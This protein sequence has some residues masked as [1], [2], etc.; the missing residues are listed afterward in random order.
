MA[1]KSLPPVVNIAQ[2]LVED[3][4]LL[5]HEDYPFSYHFQEGDGRIMILAGDNATGKSLFSQMVSLAAFHT[6]EVEPMIVSMVRRT[7]SGLGRAMTYGDESCQS[8]GEMSASVSLKALRN[9]PSRLEEYGAGMVILDE[10]DIGLSEGFS[11]AFGEKVALMVNSLPGDQD[12]NLLITSHSRK[13]LQGLVDHLDRRPTFVHTQE[14]KTLEG[15][16]SETPQRS[17]AEL[18]AMMTDWIHDFR[19]VEGIMDEAGSLDEERKAEAEEP[20]RPARGRRP[21]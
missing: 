2:S 3:T 11:Y 20:A 17:V 7:T 10:P 5:S 6:H 4:F 8:T 14:P 21:A 9:L 1:M 16:L 12:W 19:R 13:M 18:E 15:W